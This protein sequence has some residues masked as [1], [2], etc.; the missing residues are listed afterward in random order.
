MLLPVSQ[1]LAHP[2]LLVGGGGAPAPVSNVCPSFWAGAVPSLLPRWA[3][4]RA[5]PVAG[6][7]GGFAVVTFPCLVTPRSGERG[8][9][10]TG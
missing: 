7:K 3:Q 10:G 8:V 4:L 1:G 9:Q 6:Q 5:C 2:G